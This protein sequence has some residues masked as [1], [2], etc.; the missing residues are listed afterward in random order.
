MYKLLMDG[1]VKAE[2]QNEVIAYCEAKTLSNQHNHNV[3]LLDG[4]GE[5]VNYHLPL[6]SMAEIIEILIGLSVLSPDVRGKELSPNQLLTIITKSNFG[7]N[8]KELN[9]TLLEKMNASGYH[10]SKSRIDRWFKA[11]NNPK[12]SKISNNELLLIIDLISQL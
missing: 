2:I 4:M 12:F 11:E 9:E 10:I 8:K 1:V 3:I 7:S 6:A 5:A